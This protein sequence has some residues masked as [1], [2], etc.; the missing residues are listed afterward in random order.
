MSLGISRQPPQPLRSRRHFFSASWEDGAHGDVA[1]A[2]RI[3]A[4]HLGIPMGADAQPQ[5]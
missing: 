2:H 5:A 4:H 3:G 1:G